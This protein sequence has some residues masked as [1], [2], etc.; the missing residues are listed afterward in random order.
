MGKK[1]PKA[2][3]PWETASA[4]GAWNSFTAQQQQAMNMIGQN[5]PWGS[6]DYTQTGSTWITDPTGKRIEVPTYT[7]NVNLSP[8]QQAIFERT[9]AAE[10]NLAQIAKDQSAWLNEF[11]G[12]KIDLSGVPDLSNP[13]D[14]ALPNI[15]TELGDAGPI[16]RT[17]GTDYAA[18]V[19]EVQDALMA[20]MQPYMEQDEQALRTRLINQGIRPG[21]TAWDAEWARLTRAQN[22]AR[23][24]AIINAGQEQNRLAQLEAQRAAFEN[25]AQQQ[26]F[27]QMLSGAGFTNTALQQQFGNALTQS[28][29]QNAARQQAINEAYAQRVQPLNEII[30]LMSGAQVQ[31]PNATFAQTPQV[32]V[33]GV[34]YTGLVNQKY[35]ADMANYRAGMGGLFGLGSALIG[36]LPFSDRRLKT[37]IRRVGTTDGGV[38]VYTYRYKGDSTVHMGVMAQDVPEARVM[39]PS[40]F[41]RVDYSRVR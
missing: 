20:R 5:T 39:D 13:G 19:Q 36:A 1:A 6:L 14:I 7:A 26:A 31:N 3:D 41:F 34:D 27:Q 16:T 35:Q 21:T 12:N 24:G 22:D 18:N 40:G 8:E 37:D 17:Y 28:Q 32:G 2:P 38:P 33:G 25:A 10:G 23:L 4:Q 15:Q 11:L 30:G 29:A 9:Q